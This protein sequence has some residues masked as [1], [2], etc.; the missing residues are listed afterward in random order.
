MPLVLE[1]SWV[2]RRVTVRRLLGRG[3]DGRLHFGDVVG[4]LLT[5]DAETA[6]ID[7]REGLVEVPLELVAAAKPAPPSTRDELA[8]EAVAAR[9][10]RAAETGEIGG[11]LLRADHGFTG[12]ANSVLPLQPPGR[13]LDE[14]LAAARA[15]YAER[16]LPLR[17]QI[18]VES[19]RLL[20]AELAERG[21][22]ADPVVHVLATRLDTLAT[23]ST[24]STDSTDSTGPAV[25]LDEAPDDGWLARF[26]D[27]AGS[28]PVARMV[29]TRHDHARFASIT[30][31]GRIVAIGRGAIDDHWLG[32][33]AVEVESAARR[34]GLATAVMRALCRWGQANGATHSY[35]QVSA[36]NDAAVGL[37]RRLGYWPHHDYHYRREP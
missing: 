8:L 18:P 4:D 31:A 27:G 13:P 28:S 24:N 14:A 19:R 30:A 6:V 16:G 34:Q 17:M 21:W 37:Y 1:P 32:V 9:G 2:G 3:P 15:W 35:L 25:R 11:W 10:W 20:D 26:R 33:T 36:A 7:A 5:L 12:R 22:P 23:D 29:L